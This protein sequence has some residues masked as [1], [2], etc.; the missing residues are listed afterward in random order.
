MAKKKKKTTPVTVVD[1]LTA[2]AQAH[3]G[4]NLAGSPE[5]GRARLGQLQ[6]V[7]GRRFGSSTALTL[8]AAPVARVMRLPFG[9]LML[10]WKTGGVVI[11][12]INRLQGRKSTLKSTLCLRVLVQA[13]NTCRHCKFPIVVNP[14]T[15][16]VDCCCP[17]P[18]WWLADQDDYSWLVAKDAIAVS[19][20]RL[21]D[22]VEWKRVKGLGDTK[23]PVLT[24][25]P[26]PH[27]ATNKDGSEKKIK[28]KP[29]DVLFEPMERCE[30]WRCIYLDSEMCMVDGSEVFDPETGELNRVGDV[31][32]GREAVSVLSFGE[33]THQRLESCVVAGWR[34]NGVRPTKRVMVA[35]G[36][37]LETTHNHPWL[38]CRGPSQFEWVEAQH[39]LPGD[40]ICR[41]R[42]CPSP[43]SASHGAV[44]DDLARLVGYL[45][46]DGT[47]GGKTANGAIRLCHSQADVVGDVRTIVESRGA[48][49]HTLPSGRQHDV[50]EHAHG[51]DRK[52][53]GYRGELR[54]WLSEHGLLGQ[55]VRSKHIPPSLW[56]L[57]DD[58]ALGHVVAGLIATDGTVHKRRPSVGFSTT[59]RVLAYQYRWALRRLGVEARL[60]V[61]QPKASAHGVGYTLYANGLRNLRKL[62]VVAPVVGPKGIRLQKWAAKKNKKIPR[63]SGFDYYPGYTLYANGPEYINESDVHFDRVVRIEDA[64]EQHTWD[65]TVPPHHN[66]VAGDFV[67]HNTIDE[68]WA[69]ANGVDTSLVLLVGSRW[70]EQ[71]LESLEEAV[72][73]KE[74]DLLII[75]STSMLQPRGEVEKSLEANPKVAAKAAL[76]GRWVM[77]HVANMMDAGLTSRY[78]PTILCTSQMTMHGLGSGIQPYLA[79]TDGNRFDH[80]L[81]LDIRMTAKGYQM[82]TANEH[83]VYGRFDFEVKKN[84]AGGS[85]GAKASI[86]F[87]V[88]EVE[89]HA[90][91]DSDDLATVMSYARELGDGYILEGRG[92]QL[93]TLFS[94]Y[95][96]DGSVAFS[97]VGDC[98]TFLQSNPTV[99]NDLRSRVLSRLRET[100]LPSLKVVLPALE[101]QALFCPHCNGPMTSTGCERCSGSV[102]DGGM[103]M[104]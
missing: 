79:P 82:D 98:T 10:D 55:T 93:L 22:G 90:V 58:R 6:N 40:Y 56:R 52:T 32:R 103:V 94:R 1:P 75:D 50:V 66:Y 45:L 37:Y 11:G 88:R 62:A 102:E 71:S 34:D 59:S 29:K 83:A 9:I 91:G 36:E 30:P 47:L 69:R 77:R 41:P 68:A 19:Y 72:L 4:Y 42:R 33:G 26:P 21:P 23:R 14:M 85:I 57:M 97:T 84:K 24:C 3:S 20:G 31:V 27:A 25:T 49:L 74:F 53:C 60:R 78:V 70:A 100:D 80:A 48:R 104:T 16:E 46:G 76:M 43:S 12:R 5:R 96:V 95:V 65:M 99:Y 44:H 101:V 8:D 51:G 38:V 81:S 2:A 17:N 18:R 28:P 92:K 7:L 54:A 86:N 39:L 15:G 63:Q 87:W 89:G 67:V 13:Q 73:S 35:N 64:G 61:Q